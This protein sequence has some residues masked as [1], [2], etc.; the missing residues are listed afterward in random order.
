[1]IKEGIEEQ[2]GLIKEGQ[3]E[4]ESNEEGHGGVG[5]E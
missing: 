1:M 5:V 2:E 3:G 4:A